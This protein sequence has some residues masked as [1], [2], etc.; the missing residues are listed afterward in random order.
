MKKIPLFLATT[1]AFDNSCRC[2]SRIYN[3]ITGQQNCQNNGLDIEGCLGIGR[4]LCKWGPSE[5]SECQKDINKYS[6]VKN[7]VYFCQDT[8]NC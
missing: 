2:E 4:F 3:S 7:Q 1:S 8:G 6:V 5:L